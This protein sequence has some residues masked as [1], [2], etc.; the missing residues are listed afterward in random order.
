MGTIQHNIKAIRKKLGYTQET[1]ADVLGIARTTYTE[2]EIKDADIPFETL[3]KLSDFFGVE[4]VS[5]FAEN[6]S[7]LNDALV[8]AFRTDGVSVED[9]RKIAKFK[10]IVK[11]YIK[12]Q[13]IER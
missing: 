11:N 2:Y 9:L 13:R 6:D 4:L 10:T 7:Q 3:E 1:V 8:C 5:F 12:M